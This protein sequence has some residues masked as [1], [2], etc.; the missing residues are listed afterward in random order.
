MAIH[1][2]S[3]ELHRAALGETLFSAEQLICYDKK[4]EKEKWNTEEGCLGYPA[5]ILLLSYIDS[6][7]NLFH[8]QIVDGV[9]I[10]EEHSYKIL[11]TK[12]FKNQ[13][14]NDITIVDFYGCYRNKLI[15]NHSLPANRYIEPNSESNI[16]YE[17]SKD[18]TKKNDVISKIYLKPLLNLCK[19]A[20]IVIE[21]EHLDYFNN[22]SSAK[23]ITYKDIKTNSENV[24]YLNTSGHIG[25]NNPR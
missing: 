18:I 20:F 23:N 19:D 11:N 8:N 2:N 17:V 10:T 5:A 15:H 6:I 1:L 22:S 24:N 9:K 21:K 4:D 3:F 12:Y 16:W 25:F 13:N 14:I 7:G